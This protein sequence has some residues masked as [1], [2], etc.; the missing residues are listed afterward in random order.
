MKNKRKQL[1]DNFCSDLNDMNVKSPDILVH[2]PAKGCL[3][4]GGLSC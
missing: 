1:R 3:S 4:A 2:L